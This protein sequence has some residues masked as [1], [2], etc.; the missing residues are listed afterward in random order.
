MSVE[1][2]T[3]RIN[4]LLNK[5]S[6]KL[7]KSEVEKVGNVGELDILCCSDDEIHRFSCND[8][9]TRDK[10]VKKVNKLVDKRSKRLAE[11]NSGLFG[12]VTGHKAKAPDYNKHDNDMVKE[13]EK[14]MRPTIIAPSNGPGGQ[15]LLDINKVEKGFD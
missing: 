1:R 12:V 15:K 7:P 3:R 8:K 4:V 5:T 9:T 6:L 13:I 2:C 14:T 10:W 11:I